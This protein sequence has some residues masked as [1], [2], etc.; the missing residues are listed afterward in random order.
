MFV[1][2]FGVDE[3]NVCMTADGK[4]CVGFEMG[5]SSTNP[6]HAVNFMYVDIPQD[7]TALRIVAEYPLSDLPDDLD[8]ASLIEA[9]DAQDQES[10]APLKAEIIK[11]CAAYGITAD[12]LQFWWD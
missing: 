9:Q 2:F 7:G 12:K 4:H 5:D 8:E 10:Y 1:N 6:G 3:S 11:Q